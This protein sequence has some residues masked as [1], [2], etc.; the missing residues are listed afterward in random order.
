MFSCIFSILIGICELLGHL[1]PGE[2]TADLDRHLR[3]L[4]GEGWDEIS[5]RIQPYQTS[6][7]ISIHPHFL[8]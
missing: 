5:F 1:S 6:A 8:G 2:R 3:F 4:G 7:L